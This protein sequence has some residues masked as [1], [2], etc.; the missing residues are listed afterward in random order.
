VGRAAH[1]RKD[2]ACRLRAFRETSSVPLL[3]ASS[4]RHL[5]RPTYLKGI[6][7]P[8]GLH[9][10]MRPCRQVRSPLGAQSPLE[11]RRISHHAT[12]SYCSW[13]ACDSRQYVILNVL[14]FLHAALGPF[15]PSSH[16]C[17]PIYLSSQFSRHRASASTSSFFGHF[18]IIPS[19]STFLVLSNTPS[20]HAGV[21]AWSPSNHGSQRCRFCPWQ[22][23]H[24]TNTRPRQQAQS[25]Q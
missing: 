8:F 6:K 11:F 14:G 3:R 5:G 25:S 15:H 4:I 7:V 10:S 20:V 12:I 22:P 16:L 18:F 9:A 1:R 17:P 21:S 2:P 24:A 23:S 19:N 13:S